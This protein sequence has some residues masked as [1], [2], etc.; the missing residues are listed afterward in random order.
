[1]M[2]KGW[3]NPMR[4]SDLPIQRKLL[5]SVLLAVSVAATVL[6]LSVSIYEHNVLRPRLVEEART[7]AKMLAE[8]LLPSINFS[9]ASS[10]TLKL[11]SIDW[12]AE[13]LGSVIYLANGSQFVARNRQPDGRFA[14]RLENPAA[15]AKIDDSIITVIEP[16]L[17]KDDVVGW[18][19]LKIEASGARQHIY[20]YGIFVIASIVAFGV[21]G[22]LLSYV[23]SRAVSGPILSLMHA[24]QSVSEKKDY[25]LRVPVGGRDEFGRLAGA[26]N[27]MLAAIGTRDEASHQKELRLALHNCGLVELAQTEVQAQGDPELQLRL[28]LAILSRVHRVQRVGFWVFEDSDTRLRCIAAYDSEKDA[29]FDGGS[30][31][32]SACPSYFEAVRSEYVLAVSDTATDPVVAD[33]RAS[34]L[35][36]AGITAMLDLPVR[37]HGKLVGVLCHE[38]IGPARIWDDQEINF[39][40]T[41]SDRVVLMLESAELQ[42]A[43]RALREIEAHYREMVEAAPDAIFTIDPDGNIREPNTA[44]SRLTKWPESH[45]R[46]TSLANA[47][48]GQDRRAAARACEEVA[49]NGSSKA[50]VLRF[51]QAD[52]GMV[53]LECSLAPR[54]EA[55]GTSSILCVGRDQT[56]RLSAL[57]AQTKLEEQLRQAQKIEAVGTLAGGI[58]HDFNNILTALMGNLELMSYEIPEGH[59]MRPYI[60][61]TLKASLR[62]RDLV[63]QILTFSRPQDSH[64]EPLD[65]AKIVGEALGLLRASLP[66]TIE[67]VSRLDRGL[68]TILADETQIHQVV[69]NL[70]TNASHAMA[71]TG[72]KLSVEVGLGSVDAKRQAIY[73]HL[74][75]GQYVM[76]TVSDTGCGM[77]DETVRRLFE[78]FFTTKLDGQG[79]GLGMAVVHGILQSHE[80]MISVES[81]P[82]KGTTFRL[83]FPIRKGKSAAVSMPSKAVDSPAMLGSG[84]VLVIDDESAVA[85]VAEILLKRTGFS[86]QSYCDPREAIRAF[87]ADPAGIT[88]VVTDLTMPYVGGLDLT[89]RFRA[90]RPDLPIIIMTGYG[91]DNIAEALTEAGVQTILQKPFTSDVFSK[92][93]F[94]TLKSAGR[95][96]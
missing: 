60:E 81:E 39:T 22:L 24:A 18:L 76:L 43:Q 94:S 49:S 47:L 15:E 52:G 65:L 71:A 89:R 1:M 88:L 16:I 29:Y 90:L 84:R 75:L 48:F 32:V 69:M 3:V 14:A 21:L 2:K 25:S 19:G 87:E 74:L 63:R 4:F 45:W 11:A 61:N 17:S 82:G 62:A 79:T 35:E 34:Y 72:G 92:A 28:I 59:L 20:G 53:S 13:T 44:L 33:L 55:A 5:G 6:G 96:F 9:D 46:E 41:V 50:L 66:T 26:F 86:V 51:M 67:I 38:H 83:F 78:P 77:D 91:G 64:R 30:L 57:A 36:P 40:K 56:E 10:T 54:R 42:A 31:P 85:Q 8:L 58:A 12:R 7:E 70:A 95:I 80:A 68:P 73:P 23:L 93:V 37:R 27:E